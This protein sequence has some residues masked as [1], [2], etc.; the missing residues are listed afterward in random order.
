MRCKKITANLVKANFGS[1]SRGKCIRLGDRLFTPSEFEA[2]CGRSASK[3]WKRSIKFQDQNLQTLIDDGYLQLH[4]SSCSCASCLED[5]IGAGPVRLYKPYKRKKRNLYNLTPVN[6]NSSNISTGGNSSKVFRR[7]VSADTFTDISQGATVA[8]P[9]SS[10]GQLNMGVPGIIVE[11]GNRNNSSNRVTVT[12]SQ[13][14]TKTNSITTNSSSFTSPTSNLSSISFND[15]P[16][17]KAWD[18]MNEV[19]KFLI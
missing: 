16:L 18:Q 5:P 19:S 17:D 10:L 12:V 13:P 2:H 8:L 7:C 1:G 15:L 6:G 11:G 14:I 4:A 9:V 3:D